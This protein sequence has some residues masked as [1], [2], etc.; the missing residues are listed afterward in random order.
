[1]SIASQA[2]RLLTQV[3][4]PTRFSQD[5]FQRQPNEV[6]LGPFLDCI[7]IR[8]NSH[9]G[10]EPGSD[11]ENVGVVSNID[12]PDNPGFSFLSSGSK[13][14]PGKRLEIQTEFTNVRFAGQQIN[15]IAEFIPSTSA[16]PVLTIITPPPVDD[17]LPA[18]QILL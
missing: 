1:M 9:P 4:A 2:R 11:P 17:L 7:V 12:G 8:G 5:D 3:Q 14:R 13:I 16:Y 18:M 15:P 10:A 6:K